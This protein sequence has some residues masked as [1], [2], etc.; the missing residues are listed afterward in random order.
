MPPW[1]Q[2]WSRDSDLVLDGS[3]NF[4]IR[5]VLNDVCLSATVPWVYGACVAA[6]G[7]VLTVR[8][9]QTPCLRCVVGEKP[10]PGTG[11][12]C[13]TVGV[14]APAVQAVAGF[15]GAEALKL[16]TGDIG[17]LLPGLV[18]LDLWAGGFEVTDLSG[19]EPW[20]PSCVEARYDYAAASR[21][22]AS[23]LCGREAVQLPAGD[24]VDL[25]AL[26]ARLR[27]R[28]RGGGERAPRALPLAGG[29]AGGLRRRTDDRQGCDGRGRRPF[30]LC[31]LRGSLKKMN[32]AHRLAQIPPG[33]QCFVGD[34]ARRRRRIEE[35]V[36][37]V[38]EGWD[39]EEIIPP[40]FD[41][42]DVFTGEALSTK[43][44]SF[45]G[46]DGS[47]LALRPDF[48]SLLAKIAAGRLH[49]RPAPDPSLLL[50]GGRALRAA[51]GGPPERAVPDGAR[52]PGGEPRAA[53]AEVLTIAAESLERLGV[54]GFVLTLGHV[55]V[56]TG[57][58]SGAGLEGSR[59]EELRE[60]VEAKDARG[61]RD[62]LESADLSTTAKDA[63]EK[64]T[65]LAGGPEVLDEAAAAVADCPSAARAVAELQ[66]VTAILAAAGLES[67]VT[68]D[69]GEV[70][71]LDYYTGLVFRVFAP[72]LGFEVGGG[73]RYDSL[74]ARFGRPLP[75]VGFM[76]GLDR[77]A[78]LL[79]RQNAGPETE[80][81]PAEAVSGPDLGE[82]LRTAREK[83]S[84]GTRV[85]FGNGGA[86]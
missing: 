58:L 10:A 68:V 6:H 39:Y 60:R 24:A 85:R 46:R 64:L 31:A 38:F 13:D 45:V 83:R 82:A 57:L 37:S 22:K 49:D 42:A 54:E 44:Y 59:L 35:T 21:S 62:V 11:Q 29:G 80:P 50:R 73:G 41:Y 23:I 9:G 81:D 8:P 84:K 1:P 52:A 70:R 40:L 30:R 74:L 75:A 16:L 51:E 47:V 14:V 20:C 33:V 36:L 18:S 67:H 65:T 34:E 61:V 48:T 32:G 2:T 19:R 12:T 28:R 3:D 27:R 79:A 72:G 4:E 53:D 7:A 66:G 17:A 78:L 43:T 77:V 25:G 15:Q 55:G 76:L 56:F 63:L 5:Y 86:R 71:G 69:L 26:A